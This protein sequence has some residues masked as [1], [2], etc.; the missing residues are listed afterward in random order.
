MGD[1]K[2]ALYYDDTTRFPRERGDNAK[3]IT[4]FESLNGAVG[5]VAALALRLR[6]LAVRLVGE[7]QAE[8]GSIAPTIPGVFGDV[9]VQAENLR[10]AARQANAALD[11]TEQQLP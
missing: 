2:G 5:D 8:E 6:G 7:I 4:P 11:R 3:P 10:Y 1:I 9:A